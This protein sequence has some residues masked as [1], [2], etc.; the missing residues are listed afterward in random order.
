MF[1]IWYRYSQLAGRFLSVHLVAGLNAQE[2]STVFLCLPKYSRVF[3]FTNF[4][5]TY[6]FV[7]TYIFFLKKDF[8]F[9][10][11][12]RFYVKVWFYVLFVGDQSIRK[13]E[14]SLYSYQ[15]C[16]IS[17]RRSIQSA[18]CCTA[19]P[20]RSHTHYS[21]YENIE[22]IKIYSDFRV[23]GYFVMTKRRKPSK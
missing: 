11:E 9:S 23:Q 20:I 14:T 16:S 17:K 12:I 8:L 18:C 5:C 22:A 15:Y 6:F 19:A 2:I 7:F 21:M 3:D 13:I 4:D 10:K 1:L